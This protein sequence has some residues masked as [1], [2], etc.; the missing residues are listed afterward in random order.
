MRHIKPVIT[1][2]W[3][4][5]SFFL[6]VFLIF[7]YINILSIQKD[8]IDFFLILRPSKYIQL[9][10]HD[11]YFAFDAYITLEWIV[12]LYVC[13]NIIIWCFVHFKEV[14]SI[15]N[16]RIYIFILW[17]I[18][19]VLLFIYLLTNYINVIEIRT[20][21]IDVQELDKQTNILVSDI[22]AA[23]DAYGSIVWIAILY[24]GINIFLFIK[25]HGYIRN[26]II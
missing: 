14:R 22:Y 7:N 26:T 5:I 20:A 8:Q 2:A 23:L 6:I 25:S 1:I 10:G 4:F 12:L 13:L 16:S 19:S 15:I 24:I 11:L 3:L 21:Q 9:T 17:L 18:I